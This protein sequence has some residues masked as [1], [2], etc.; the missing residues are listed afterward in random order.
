M[1]LRVPFDDYGYDCAQRCSHA[2]GRRHGVR[3][4]RSLV[5]AGGRLREEVCESDLPPHFGA[6]SAKSYSTIRGLARLRWMNDLPAACWQRLVHSRWLL[7]PPL[8]SI[9]LCPLAGFGMAPD[10][11][12]LG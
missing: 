8:P 3:R 2:P 4:L 5:L 1:L 6:S 12:K 10:V 7:L 9:E 11:K